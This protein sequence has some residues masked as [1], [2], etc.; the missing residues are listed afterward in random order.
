MNNINN[1]EFSICK[2]LDVNIFFIHVLINL[3]KYGNK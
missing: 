3:Y 2:Y 1:K